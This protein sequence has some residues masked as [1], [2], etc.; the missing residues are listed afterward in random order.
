MPVTIEV[1]APFQA[2]SKLRVSSSIRFTEHISLI[3]YPKRIVKE[4]DSIF[5]Q[6]KPLEFTGRDHA[7]FI[8]HTGHYQEEFLDYL[9]QPHPLGQSVPSFKRLPDLSICNFLT[10]CDLVKPTFFWIDIEILR[11][12]LNGAMKV[13]SIKRLACHNFRIQLMSRLDKLPYIEKRD[14]KKLRTL[15][16]HIE[17][18]YLRGP[19]RLRQALIFY[20]RALLTEDLEFVFLL[21]WQ[22]LESLF[23]PGTE[24]SHRI[25]ETVASV[26]HPFG[27]DR[28]EAHE[29]LRRLYGD[30]SKIVHGEGRTSK[31]LPVLVLEISEYTRQILSVILQSSEY[32]K[33]LAA[34][35]PH[36]EFLKVVL[37]R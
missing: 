12:P 14:V 2:R 8:R 35:K 30:R 20:S 34:K 36:K 7:P 19:R 29:Q 5:G 17:E 4:A 18:T 9:G 6:G 21:H 27:S 37:G 28:R 23:S 15:L 16:Q 24:V 1:Y 3:P 33:F 25:C 32:R 31:N 11:A 13:R 22:V 10:A 26:L